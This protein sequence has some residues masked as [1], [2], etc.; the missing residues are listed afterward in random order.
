V[1]VENDPSGGD[2]AARFQLSAKRGWCSFAA[3]SRRL[4][5]T[6]PIQP[7][8]QRLPGGLEV[9]VGARSAEPGED[10]AAVPSL[11]ASA[12]AEGD[13][14]W[15]VV[16]DLGR[17]LAGERGAETWFERST[18]VAIVLRRD[19]ASILHLRDRSADIRSR[20]RGRAGLVI[21]GDG[22]FSGQDIERFVGLPL[23][24]ELPTDP[25]SAQICGGLPG[26]APRLSRS[27]LVTSAQRLAS[28]L[29]G[30]RPLSFLEPEHP[31]GGSAASRL[32]D[33]PE[34]SVP[35]E[36]R[37]HR[38]E[39]TGQDR[40]KWPWRRKRPTFSPPVLSRDEPVPVVVEAESE[41]V[42]G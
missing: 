5:G 40:A 17:L 6:E 30:D 32:L 3:A 33:E 37:A 29:S 25:D 41:E 35:P 15:D 31:I 18:V 9:L 14:G 20:S 34:G 27:V 7:H 2:L 10:G 42:V 23:L 8:V 13:Q 19:A 12:G 22:P 4:E 39:R 38:N 1:L 28:I 16:A 21:V 11:L 24:G 26:G 36:L